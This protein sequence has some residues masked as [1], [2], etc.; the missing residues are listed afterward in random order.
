MQDLVLASE[1][2]AEEDEPVIHQG[3]HEARVLVETVLLAKVAGPIPWATAFEANRKEHGPNLAIGRASRAS[4]T[5]RDV[6][7]RSVSRGQGTG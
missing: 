3:V 6:S 5:V 1:R 4:A 7:S 2:P